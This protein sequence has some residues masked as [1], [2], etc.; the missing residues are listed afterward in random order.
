MDACRGGAVRVSRTTES[1]DA[2]PQDDS[3]GPVGRKRRPMGVRS[4]SV[5]ALVLFA[6][7]VI[8]AVP[9][10]SADQDGEP[11]AQAAGGDLFQSGPPP[12]DRGGEGLSARLAAIG[13]P[14]LLT[15]GAALH[16][17]Q[18]LDVF[19]E[20]DRV[21][22]PAGI[23]ID[24]EGRFIAPIHTHGSEGIVHIEADEVRPYT[25]GELFSVWGVRFGDGCL[26]DDCSSGDAALRVYVDGKS[27]TAA[28]DVVLDDEQVIVVAFGSAGEVPAR[29]RATYRFPERE[30]AAVP[31][32]Q[33]P[34]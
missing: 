23:G 31:A 16:I 25:L 2:G 11:P 34:G 14:E 8:L 22:V 10:L 33:P 5:A 20:G 26:G 12:W 9:F 13:L 17:H 28:A 18:H 27:V 7:G 1:S 32:P 24:P 30:R 15:E 4:R 29:I 6:A 21:Q 3:I 19:V